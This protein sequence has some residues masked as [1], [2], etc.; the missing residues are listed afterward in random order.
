MSCEVTVIKIRVTRGQPSLRREIGV[1]KVL[2]R[3]GMQGSMPFLFLCASY[4]YTFGDKGQ[5]S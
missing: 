5:R 1:Q 2:R 3:K 4:Y